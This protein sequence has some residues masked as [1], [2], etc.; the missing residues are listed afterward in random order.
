MRKTFDT[1]TIGGRIHWCRSRM[2]LTQ[3]QLADRMHVTAPL[4]SNYEKNKVDISVR[5]VYELAEHLDTTASYLVDAVDINIEETE[6]ELLEI[7]GT[8]QEEDRRVFLL[9]QM[10]M[11]AMIK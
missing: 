10:K 5:V 9:E 1:S 4:I 6:R 7:F 2:K 11:F 8:I 3:E